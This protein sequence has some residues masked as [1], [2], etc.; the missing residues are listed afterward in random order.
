MRYAWIKDHAGNYPVAILCHTLD[1]S[2]SGYYDWLGRKP[3]SRQQRREQIAAAAGKS[4]H[5]SNR[6]YGY[7]KVHKDVV[8]EA[9][10]DCCLETVRRV[11]AEKGLFSRVKRRFVVTTDSKHNQ[12]VAENL[13]DRD[14]A[15]SAPNRKWTADITYIP[16]AEGWLY[17]SAVMD[18]YSRRIV[19]WSMSADIDAELVC[20]ALRMA[21][22][23]RQPDDGLMHHSDRGRQ[24]TAGDFV[25]LLN[26]HKITCSMSR[27][28]NCWD[29]AVMESFFG[30]LKTEWTLG[31][32]YKTRA[33]AMQDIFKYVEVFYNRKRRHASL[34]YVSPAAYEELYES[35]VTQAA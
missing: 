29:N 16:T 14:F 4:Y 3:S 31:K 19:G 10:I 32:S 1:V 33:E 7:R 17:L 9:K 28:G 26:E 11:L 13:L 21:V 2:V 20:D 18:L 15:G 5:D 12:P 27:K 34:G 30:S 35:M 22:L 8:Q 24:Y 25:K 6:I 23:Q